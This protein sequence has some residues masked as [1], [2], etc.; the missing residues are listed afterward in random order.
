MPAALSKMVKASAI[1]M[2]A[3]GINQTET[4]KALGISPWTAHRWNKANRKDIEE[5]ALHYVDASI[6]PIR[7]NHI[8]QLQL[9]AE[10]SN[11][12]ALPELS[13]EQQT[14]LDNIQSRLDTIGLS[15]RDLILISDK[16]EDRALR[17]MG[18]APS[19]TQSIILNQLFVGASQDVVDPAVDTLLS[20]HCP[21]LLDDE[22]SIEA[23]YTE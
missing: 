22:E 3:Q 5:L 7:E 14:R 13:E 8:N 2:M 23:E 15:A 9:S 16:K 17:I 18:I 11:L 21:D 1:E 20:H 10:I 6:K 4:G 12:I 19:N